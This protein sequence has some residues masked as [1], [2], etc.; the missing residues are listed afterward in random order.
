MVLK[1]ETWKCQDK[2]EKIVIDFF[3]NKDGYDV[4]CYGPNDINISY[5][6]NHSDKPNLDLAVGKSEYYEF[7]TNRKIKKGEELF[8]NYNL[9]DD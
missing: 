5:Y 1:K 2:T 7:I 9:Y 4:L 6:L 3:G 8:I